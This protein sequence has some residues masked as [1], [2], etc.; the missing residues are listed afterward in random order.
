MKN[1]EKSIHLEL[2]KFVA[3]FLILNGHMSE[4][5]PESISYLA[6]GGT[7]GDGLFFF[8][9]GY[10]LFLGRFDRF[11]NWYARRIRRIFPSVIAWAVL[12][13]VIFHVEYNVVDILYG[14]NRWFI[15]CIM[16]YYI[17][18]FFI[19]KY[20]VNYKIIIALS[21]IVPLGYYLTL[22]TTSFFMYR[23]GR[24]TY[25]FIFMLL[26]AFLGSR[27]WNFEFG[28]GVTNATLAIWCIVCHY[29]ISLSAM[30]NITMA[31]LQI[32]SLVPLIGAVIFLHNLS[33]HISNLLSPRT[34]KYLCIISGLCLETY[35]V[36]YTFF[37]EKWNY[38]FPLNI[39]G[40][41]AVILLVAYITRTL[42]RIFV[43]IFSEN[44]FNWNLIFKL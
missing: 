1:R 42:G 7:I 15:S 34:G 14:T 44:D 17:I 33:A 20:S 43:Q 6:T 21:I 41:T 9:S 27:K 30:K 13:Y 18:L 19:R 10:T 32:L 2:L 22:D 28:N 36:Q 5:Y 29:L 12:S 8:C 3:I 11:D 24:Y 35:L 25:W 40:V 31:H 26:G 4:M 39:I 38:L 16:I 37:T 23:G